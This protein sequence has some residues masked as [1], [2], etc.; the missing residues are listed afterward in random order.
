[1]IVSYEALG[2]GA[3]WVASQIGS[4]MVAYPR[5]CHVDI[6]PIFMNLIYLCGHPSFL[7]HDSSIIYIQF[8]VQSLRPLVFCA[9]K[10]MRI[11]PTT[12]H[13]QGYKRIIILN[14]NELS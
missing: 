8:C 6:K 5:I 13:K 14:Y 7:S 9:N 11:A 4:F 1:M 2:R 12:S 10:T 3:K